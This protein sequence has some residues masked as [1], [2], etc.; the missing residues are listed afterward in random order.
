[1]HP[2]PMFVSGRNYLDTTVGVLNRSYWDALG[3][4]LL[5]S[6]SLIRRAGGSVVRVP[7]CRWQSASTN[8]G[9]TQSAEEESRSRAQWARVAAEALSKAPVQPKVQN[10]YRKAAWEF[11]CFLGVALCF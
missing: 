2:N 4:D 5:I 9:P 6:H 11:L 7:T 1:M 3:C 8:A 10:H